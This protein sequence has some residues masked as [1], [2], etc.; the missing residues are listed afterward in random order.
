MSYEHVA[1]TFLFEMFPKLQ[2]LKGCKGQS[3]E[4]RISQMSLLKC[5]IVFL[6]NI[7]QMEVQSSVREFECNLHFGEKLL[8]FKYE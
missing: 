1:R 8:S 6:R 3:Y 5:Q 7:L 4:T 2:L